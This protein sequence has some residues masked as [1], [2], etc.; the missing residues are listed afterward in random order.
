MSPETTKSKLK[1]VQ[2]PLPLLTQKHNYKLL[3][4]ENEKNFE[5]PF[6]NPIFILS[7]DKRDVRCN[8]LPS[9]QFSFFP[10][11]PHY[12]QVDPVQVP[13]NEHEHVEQKKF[14]VFKG[15]IY[16]NSAPSTTPTP[17]GGHSC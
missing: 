3:K 17:T 8:L 14:I 2:H 4:H 13:H 12:W 10:P 11:R 7:F 15:T 5:S 9:V 16:L 6:L 1:N